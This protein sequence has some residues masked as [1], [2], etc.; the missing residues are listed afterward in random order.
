MASDAT[1]GWGGEFHLSS[2]ATEAGLVELSEVTNISGLP[3]EETEDVEVTHLKS[4]NRRREYIAGFRG[5]SDVQVTMNYVPGSASDV[6][7]RA[8]K[9]AGDTRALRF[10]IPDQ[11]GDPAWEVDTFGYVKGY[12]RGPI[13]PDGKIE[14]VVTV[15]IT[16]DQTEAAA[17]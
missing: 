16:G 9:D 10:V 7:I 6:L 15:R 2:N 3:D 14:A 1:I 11:T 12:S 13:S 5:T 4:P 17:A 8:A